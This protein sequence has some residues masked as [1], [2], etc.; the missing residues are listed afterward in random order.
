LTISVAIC[1]HPSRAQMATALS[2][3]LACPISYDDGVGI[4]ANHDRALML[5]ADTSQPEDWCVVIEDD[6][7]PID[8]FMTQAT[9]ALDT[10]SDNVASL[11]LGYFYKPKRRISLTLDRTDPH[12]LMRPGFTSAVCIAVRT[13]FVAQLLDE[14]HKLENMT[15]DQRYSYAAK[16]CGSQWVPHSYPS[17][18]EHSDV[19][20][21]EG[22]CGIPRHAYK[23]GGRE[24]WTSRSLH[25]YERVWE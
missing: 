18:V 5:A 19:P 23:V 10:I 9:T 11:Y 25:L 1:A 12:W 7:T 14:A 4:I 13:S 21:V 15:V 6:A 16:S 8:D 17:L 3:Q 2:L 22:A 24:A 20:G